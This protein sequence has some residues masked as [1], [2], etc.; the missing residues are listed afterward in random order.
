MVKQF[1]LL[2]LFQLFI[3]LVR[4]N[5]EKKY[6]FVKENEETDFLAFFFVFEVKVSKF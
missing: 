2:L 4:E 6:S 5:S 3:F 1:C